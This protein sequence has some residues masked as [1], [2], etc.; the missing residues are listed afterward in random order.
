MRAEQLVPASAVV[1]QLVLGEPERGW[2]DAER[3]ADLLRTRFGE[4][5]IRPAALLRG[6]DDGR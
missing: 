1:E 3:A 6:A 2:R 5:V 4:T